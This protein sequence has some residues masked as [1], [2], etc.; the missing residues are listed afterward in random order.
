MK[1]LSEEYLFAYIG[2]L[3]IQQTA[4]QGALE[5]ALARLEV[6]EQAMVRLHPPLQTQAASKDN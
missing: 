3:A 2:K 5:D 6:A 1:I 4:L